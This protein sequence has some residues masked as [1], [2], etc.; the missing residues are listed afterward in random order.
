MARQKF[1][2]GRSG[3]CSGGGVPRPVA[4][5]TRGR[6][7]EGLELGVRGRAEGVEVAACWWTVT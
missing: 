3:R 6:V 7:P 5:R 1:R 2:R 4:A